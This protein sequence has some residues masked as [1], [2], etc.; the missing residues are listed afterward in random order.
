MTG[1]YWASRIL[2]FDLLGSKGHGPIDEDEWME[3]NG[4]DVQGMRTSTLLQ[5]WRDGPVRAAIFL[6]IRPMPS[7]LSAA[8]FSYPSSGRLRMGVSV[9]LLSHPGPESA[10]IVART[11]QPE[12]LRADTQPSARLSFP[13]RRWAKEVLDSGITVRCAPGRFSPHSVGTTARP[14]EL[15]YLQATTK[16]YTNARANKSAQLSQCRRPVTTTDNRLPTPPRGWNAV[17]QRRQ[18]MASRVALGWRGVELARRC[19]RQPLPTHFVQRVRSAC[20]LR[21]RRKDLQRQDTVAATDVGEEE[22]KD[23]DWRLLVRLTTR[24]SSA[25]LNPNCVSRAVRDVTACT[26][27]HG[28]LRLTRDV[29]SVTQEVWI[30]VG[31]AFLTPR[32]TPWTWKRNGIGGSGSRQR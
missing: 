5:R 24:K 14:R 11:A 13:P 22:R 25:S 16:V 2:D 4:V 10:T 19:D 18:A 17:G 29:R 9:K 32:R 7:G 3:M 8:L 21:E 6:T 28:A 26:I 20:G 12:E 31:T 27:E 15:L 30:T 1:C 23:V